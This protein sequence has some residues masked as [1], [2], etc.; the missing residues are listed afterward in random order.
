[1]VRAA[2]RFTG[3]LLAF[4]LI[5]I[6]GSRALEWPVPGGVPLEPFGSF[7]SGRFHVSMTQGPAGSRVLAAS[8]GE[9]AFLF[10]GDKLPSGLPCPLGGF[11]ALSHPDGMMSVYGRL[12]RGSMPYYLRAVSSGEVLGRA[13]ASGFHTGRESTF[14]LFDRVKRQYLNPQ[15]LLPPVRDDRPPLTRGVFL[16]SGDRSFPLGE[17]RNLKQGTYAVIADVQDTIS[18]TDTRPRAP[19]TIRLLIDGKE[20]VRYVYDAARAES[21]RLRFFGSARLDS[22]SYFLTDGRLRL[23]TFLFPRGR[24]TIV[25]IVSDYA[26]NERETSGVINVE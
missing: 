3:I 10:D 26:G 6:S 16:T 22:E 14:T 20:L 19:Y 25:L 1:M 24:S 7:L 18:A 12:E 8:D 15:V 11:V 17:T 9:I 21:G 2:R 23:G 4:A 5:P 13:G